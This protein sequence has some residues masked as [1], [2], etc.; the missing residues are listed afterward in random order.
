MIQDFAGE[1]V[2]IQVIT[3]AHSSS[4]FASLNV[5]LI[6]VLVIKVGFQTTS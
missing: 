1:K 5:F 4:I 6:N 3:P 2:C